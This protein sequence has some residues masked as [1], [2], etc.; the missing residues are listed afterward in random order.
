MKDYAGGGGRSLRKKRKTYIDG[1]VSEDEDAENIERSLDPE[2]LVKT[3]NYPRYFVTKMRGEDLTLEHFQ[4]TGFKMPILVEEKSGLHIRIPD[5]SF[6]ITDIRRPG[7]FTYSW[8][9]RICVYVVN[10]L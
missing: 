5:N 4:R 10:F 1:M 2:D 3:K 8:N 7:R 9:S 6:S